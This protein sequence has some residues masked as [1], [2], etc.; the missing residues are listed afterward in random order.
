MAWYPQGD[1]DMGHLRHMVL[2]FG[3]HWTPEQF[4]YY[5]AHLDPAGRPTEWLFD[6][7]L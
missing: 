5:A 3:D 2:L 1:P 7:F 4:R 6:S